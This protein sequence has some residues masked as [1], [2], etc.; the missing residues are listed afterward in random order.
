MLVPPWLESLLSTQFFTVCRTH[1]DAARS[2]CNMYCLDC[3]GDAFCFYCRSSRHKD[4]QVVQ[5]SLFTFSHFFCFLFIALY[6][7]LARTMRL[8]LLSVCLSKL[9]L[10]FYGFSFPFFFFFFCFLWQWA[11][12]E[13]FISWCSESFGDSEG[14]GHK[15]SSDLCDKQC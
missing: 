8:Y 2:E 1:E 12:K 5:V 7:V 14:I 13:I 6:L 15:W 4:H 9:A 3:E 10:S 11:D